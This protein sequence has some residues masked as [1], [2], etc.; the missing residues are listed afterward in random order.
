MLVRPRG[1]SRRH[2]HVR[3]RDEFAIVLDYM[4]FGNPY[5]R[6]VQHRSRPVAQALGTKFFALVEILPLKNMPLNIGERVPIAPQP[7][8][9]G[10]PVADRLSY[11]ELSSVAKTNLAKFLRDIVIEKEKVFVEFFNVAKPI[12][13]RLHSL[14]LLPGIG[15]KTLKII[16]EERK[17]KSFESFEE[18]QARTRINDP[19][20]LIVDRI[21]LELQGQEKYY[22]FVEPYP[23]SPGFVKLNYL[24]YLYKLTNYDKPW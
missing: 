18:I 3:V 7:E 12:N 23:D 16:L 19:V 11:N 4:P 15:K 5:D 9:P 1:Q 8:L 20:K 2:R 22:I 21:I 6:H 10:H 17:K 13:I 24:D 14:E